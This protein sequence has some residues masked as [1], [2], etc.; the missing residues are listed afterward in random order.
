MTKIISYPSGAFGHFLAYL[1]NYMIVGQR[2][3]VNEF[4]YDFAVSDVRFFKPVHKNNNCAVYINV[5]N[6][7][8]LKFLITNINRISGVDLIV[9]ELHIDTF[10]KVRS[11][12]TLCFFE[13]SLIEISNKSS[14]D[15]S[16]S[17]IREWLRLCFFANSCKTITEYIGA[18]PTNCYTV[19]FDTFFAR[20]S[21]KQCAIDVLR[22]F[23][24]EIAINDIDDVIDEFFSK[25]RYRNHIDTSDLKKSIQKNQNI[26]L[27]LNVV[28]QAWLDNWLVEQYSID[29]VLSDEYFKNTKDLID[30][31]NLPVDNA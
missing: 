23:G 30:F 26:P 18:R 9:D 31:Y 29:P 28:E 11:H 4:V 3:K 22:H 2:H 20:D 24:F 1:L 12:N 19:D 25:Q 10:N 27:N 8:Y 16:N 5:S 15:V 17:H 7:S 13:K 14:G 21:I 6:N